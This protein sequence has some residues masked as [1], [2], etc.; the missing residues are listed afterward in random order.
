MSVIARNAIA[1]SK[2]QINPLIQQ[3]QLQQRRGHHQQKE[4]SLRKEKQFVVRYNDNQTFQY[5]KQSKTK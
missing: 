4:K 1:L 2:N 5:Y 3:P